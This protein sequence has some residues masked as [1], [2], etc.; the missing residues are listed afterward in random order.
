MKLRSVTI[1]VV[2]ALSVLSALATP[3]GGAISTNFRAKLTGSVTSSG[4]NCCFTETFFEGTAAIPRLGLATFTGNTLEGCFPFGEPECEQLLTIDVVGTNGRTLAI[5]ST[6]DWS[7]SDPMPPLTWTGTGSGF[8]MTGTY[9]IKPD[10]NSFLPNGT[11]ITV[12]LRGAVQAVAE[13][14]DASR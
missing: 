11:P 1:G 3:A 7:P 4:G 8:T 9:R 14:G 10:I 2:V 13:A 6:L 12:E 5:T